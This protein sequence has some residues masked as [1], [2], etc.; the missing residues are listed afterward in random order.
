MIEDKVYLEITNEWVKRNVGQNAYGIKYQ[1]VEPDG[2]IIK[3]D[4]QSYV[5]A[6]NYTKEYYPECFEIRDLRKI[7]V[8]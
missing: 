3:D 5:E 6:L 8:K 2:T 4:F 7:E 1:L